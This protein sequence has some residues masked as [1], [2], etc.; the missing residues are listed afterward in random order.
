VNRKGCSKGISLNQEVTATSHSKVSL[1]YK[2]VVVILVAAAVVVV[3]VVAV[4]MVS[5]PHLLEK[6]IFPCNDPIG[7]HLSV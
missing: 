2:L 4:G 7:L 6:N 5:C 3:L 1:Y